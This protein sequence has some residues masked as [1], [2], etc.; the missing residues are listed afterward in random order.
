MVYKM[1]LAFFPLAKIAEGMFACQLEPDSPFVLLV[2]GSSTQCWRT[3]TLKFFSSAGRK[4][5]AWTHNS[6]VCSVINAPN[7]EWWLA[8]DVNCPNAH[9]SLKEIKYS[10]LEGKQMW[11][12]KRPQSIFH[13]SEKHSGIYFPCPYLSPWLL[14]FSLCF[15]GLIEYLNKL[16][17][18]R[19][20]YKTDRSGEVMFIKTLNLFFNPFSNSFAEYALFSLEISSL[21]PRLT[22]HRLIQYLWFCIVEKGFFF[23]FFSQSQRIWVH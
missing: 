2:L 1:N 8:T 14:R 13:K 11:N 16:I 4:K 15:T 7:I 5:F 3:W 10:H 23:F 19:N 21:W 18:H 22:V 9:L 12:K 6:T 17:N 20:S